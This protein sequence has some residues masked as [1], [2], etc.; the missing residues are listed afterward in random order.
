[1]DVN[2]YVGNKFD[3]GNSYEIY[4][5]TWGKYKSKVDSCVKRIKCWQCFKIRQKQLNAAS[6]KI[7]M[8]TY[9]SDIYYF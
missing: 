5:V 9:G 7:L 2:F 6:L 1:M 4:G 8:C 3:I